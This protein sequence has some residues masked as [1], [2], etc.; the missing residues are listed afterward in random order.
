MQTLVALILGLF[1]GALAQDDPYR[2]PPNYILDH[3]DLNIVFP[4]EALSGE[5]TKYSG[6]VEITFQM[7]VKTSEVK[8]H[9]SA[10]YID[11]LV[12]QLN[13]EDAL[14]N[15]DFSVNST[16]NILTLQFAQ[17]LEVGVDYVLKIT[18]DARL[19]TNSRNGIFRA[20]YIEDETTQYLIATQFES[21]YARFGFPCFDEPTY[22]A[23]FAYNLTYPPE[24]LALTNTPEVASTIN[25]ITKLKTS[26]FDTSPKMSSYLVAFTIA[27]YTC[28]EGP[29]E[30]SDD[31][32]HR[33]CSRRDK[34]HLRDYAMMV[35]PLIIDNLNSYT[36]WNYTES[37]SKLDQV[38]VSEK[39]GAMENWGLVLYSESGLLFDHTVQTNANKQSILAVITHELSHQWFGN[40]VTCKWWSEIF[41]NEG[42]ATLFEYYISDITQPTFEMEKM[43][44][45]KIIQYIM[46][47]QATLAAP[48]L[49]TNASTPTQIS[50]TFGAYSYYKG[51]AVLRMAEHI[52]GREMF[53]KGINKYLTDNAYKSVEPQDLWNALEAVSQEQPPPYPSGATL[54]DVMHEW[55][56]AG[57]FPVVTVS[58]NGSSIVMTQARFLSTE[59]DDDSIKWY[60][61]ISYSTANEDSSNE[62]TAPKGWITPTEGFVIEEFP[63]AGAWIVVNNQ[64]TGFYRVNYDT[65]LW[66]NLA[67]ALLQ[68]NFSG[69]HVLNRAQVVQDSDFLARAGLITFGQALRNTEFLENDES[70]FSWYPG[71]T[72][73]DNLLSKT[74]STSLLGKVLTNHFNRLLDTAARS[75]SLTKVDEDAHV[76]TINQ[77]LINEYACKY[78]NEFCI[79]GA[80]ELFATYKSTHERPNIN[81]RSLVYCN[82]IRYSEDPLED[83]EFLFEQY[84]NAS[85][86]Q[87]SSSIW[88]AL[89]CSTN[90]TV[91][92]AF[93]GKIFT[94]DSILTS[95]LYNS[96]FSTIYLG[97][98]AGVDLVLDYFIENYQA[99]IDAYNA[100]GLTDVENI[101]TGLGSVLTR[102][103]QILKLK[104]FVAETPDL[105]TTIAT[106]A[107]SAENTY[108]SNQQL[109]DDH[110]TSILAYFGLKEDDSADDP[111]RLPTN[112]Y[113]VHQDVD[114]VVSSEAF[115]ANYNNYSGTVAIQFQVTVETNVVKLHSSYKYI[116]ILSLHL[117]HQKPLSRALY[118]GN[119]TTDLLTI[120]FPENLLVNQKYTLTI[121]FNAQLLGGGGFYKVSYVD[122]NGETQYAATTQFQ[123]T[124]ARN[125]FPCFDEPSFKSTF[126]FTL[127]YPGELSAWTNTPSVANYTIEGTD[128]VKTVFDISPRM[129]S[130]LVAFTISRYTCTEGDLGGT[131]EISGIKHRVCSRMDEEKNRAL[132]MNVTPTI[133]EHLS[134][135]TGVNYSY[136]LSKL[137]QM[138]VPGKS[139]AM[140]NWGLVIYGE[141]AL[142]FNADIQ[143]S[144]T[145]Q[146]IT[147]IISHELSH[148]W[149]GNLLTCNWWSETYLNEGFA[150]IFQYY[151]THYVYPQMEM[152]KQFVIK[153]LQPIL[154]TEGNL[155]V[156]ALTSNASTSSEASAK[157]DS[158]SYRKGG[159]VLRMIEH[160]IGR[161]TFK[162]GIQKYVRDNQYKAVVSQDLWDALEAVLEN[163]ISHLPLGITLSE[164]VENWINKGGYPV[165]NVTLSESDLVISQQRF[166]YNE[167][168][169][170]DSSWYIPI[171][172]TISSSNDF[173]E[174]TFPKNWVTP[175]QPLIIPDFANT[176]DW[177]VVNNQE[178]GFYRVFYDQILTERLSN[179][180]R[181]SN[182]SGI[183]V[184]NRAQI[185]DDYYMFARAGFVTFGNVLKVVEFLAN[186]LDYIS[187]YPAT[188]LFWYLLQRTGSTTTLGK[189]LTN[190]FLR[191]MANAGSEVPLQVIDPDNH[192]Y[193]L[194]QN[195]IG[196][197]SCKFGNN[198][199][200]AAAKQHF[201]IYK[202]TYTRPNINIRSIVYCNSM[203]YS[204]DP[205]T[206]WN[207]LY[208]QYQNES[209]ST[210]TTIIWTALGCATNTTVLRSF[211]SKIIT[212]DGVIPASSYLSIFSAIYVATEVGVD[213]ALDF[214]IENYQAILDTFETNNL[215][216]SL[217]F[218]GLAPYITKT[219]QIKQL[220]D[221]L[222]A[223]GLNQTLINAIQSAL[224]IAKTNQEIIANHAK[225][226]YEYLGIEEDTTIATTTT[227][228][229]VITTKTTTSTLPPTTTEPKDDGAASIGGVGMLGVVLI[230]LLSSWHEYLSIF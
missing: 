32:I 180:L 208:Q 88:S 95:S 158:Y 101:I 75:V 33:V 21:T 188:N 106:A 104:N 213:T 133:I 209:V 223:D 91:L 136:S 71:I 36:G 202:T 120:T 175:T 13:N 83:W 216:A 55:I 187:W 44:L 2:L 90:I 134:D 81:T 163:E 89:G 137:D 45:V 198:T 107:T 179:A 192:L 35:T 93:L 115:T 63:E 138:A 52:V 16:T 112:Y 29:L 86:S 7:T 3:Y 220:E 100:A 98:E 165:V 159:S 50:S 148:Q 78:G 125:A 182:F 153:I 176:N 105:P 61:P 27:N 54:S 162:L 1:C 64:Q 17:D 130:Y 157:F 67:D 65:T 201:E 47:L 34:E 58:L 70:Y 76:F 68:D 196:T 211:L 57:G 141:T 129:S 80:K 168:D 181:Q 59:T 43:L 23:T 87:D 114:L 172:Y 195:L 24:F 108:R 218:T 174:D 117:D 28:S 143:T 221:F 227:P 5:S 191:L 203:R 11:L 122:H 72:L 197:Y 40:L 102:E 126:A 142:L 160:I 116:E 73:F 38:A 217:I 96:I 74:G 183:H 8:L 46:T 30:E 10:S 154:V 18:F 77:V 9:A 128:L 92:R 178:T 166:L 48:A 103:D 110:K 167:T 119:S 224:T 222:T 69:I 147:A 205:L 31:Y 164:V 225:S 226:L 145:K 124:N 20:S 215:N 155:N 39:S 14:S 62:V 6:Y 210:D 118:W 85:V 169:T 204:D 84:S 140:E 144:L 135:Y 189:A 185:I 60:I 97:N 66:N 214:F 99:I 206:D 41:L 56:E 184:V 150:T 173:N 161:E 132:A 94:T 193:T 229:A 149:F 156:P 51:A 12:I 186:D 15:E 4:A 207:F 22:K 190:H 25:E 219:A 37:L 230:A 82:A 170:E 199:C 49:R 151:T 139:G 228:N 152:E 113:I 109:I 127:T 171:S 194:Q 123:A 177:I 42:F 26:V 121:T 212:P 111:Y 131:D 200:V 146:S 53:K 19:M 79:A